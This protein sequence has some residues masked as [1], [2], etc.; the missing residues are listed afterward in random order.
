M[1]FSLLVSVISMVV[2]YLRNPRQTTP[3]VKGNIFITLVYILFSP[4][5]Y[6]GFG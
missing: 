2:P 1:I 5:L 4:S 6:W 3:A